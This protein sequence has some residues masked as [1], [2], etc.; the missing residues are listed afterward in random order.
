MKKYTYKIDIPVL[1]IFFCR[2]E[3]FKKVFEQVKLAR[4]SK[5]YLYQDG[6]RPD[7]E[8]DIIGIQ[9]CREIAEDIDWDC[10]VHKLYQDKN[11]GCDP[12]EYIAQKWMFSN[13]EMGIVLE[14]DD[15]PSQSFFYFCKELLIRYKDD[16]RINI[17]CGMNNTMVS[18]HI[19]S[20]YL[21]TK[22]GSIWGWASWKRV[23][24]T[25]DETY[26]WL[27][28]N[29]SLKIIKEQFY[30]EKEY[31]DFI[32]SSMVHRK[33]GRAHYESIL[34]ASLYLN[35]RLNIVPKYNLIS[36]IGI[37]AE[38]T[39]SVDNIK[40]LPRRTRKLLYMKTYEI[41]S[42]LKHPN[43]IERDT[44]FEDK[45]TPNKLQRISDKIE[46]IILRILYGDFKGIYR[47]IKIKI[48]GKD[49]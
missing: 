32:Q 3:Q 2:D 41:D 6:A 21:F 11:Y 47:R 33:S 40:K 44:I 10:E 9:K 42:E 24:D 1:L 28:D 14:D 35:Y 4:P 29:E 38:S 26:S 8:D 16:E 19:K 43:V 7:R 27:D 17:I 37:A 31:N 39:H 5:L 45:M 46:G 48:R 20:D 25:W 30:N 12:S 23:I 49:K 15:V 34:A 13:E 18:E 22:Q 36:N